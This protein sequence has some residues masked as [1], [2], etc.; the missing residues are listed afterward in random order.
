MIDPL[1]DASACTLCVCL[2]LLRCDGTSAE[3]RSVQAGHHTSKRTAVCR[4]EARQRV[5][6]HASTLQRPLSWCTV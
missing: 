6:P 5:R 3:A 1:I 2:L 4:S